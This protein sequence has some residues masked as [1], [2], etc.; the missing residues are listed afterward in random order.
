MFEVLLAIIAIF[1][2]F[3]N[4]PA[5]PVSAPPTPI[6][7]TAEPITTENLYQA[8]NQYRRAHDLQ[9]VLWDDTLC[10][11]AE[12]RVREIL[13]EWNHNGYLAKTNAFFERHPT[14]V[15]A[16][17]NLARNYRTTAEVM[18]AWDQS[19][20]HQANLVKPVFN[21]VCFAVHEN[22]VTQQL[23]AIR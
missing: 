17:E 8:F 14:Y 22:H 1:T 20:T 6:V 13:T 15:V 10:P 9:P 11:L 3:Q 23:G 16:G 19:P 2:F 4:A 7:A 18:D 12:I 5:A 21:R